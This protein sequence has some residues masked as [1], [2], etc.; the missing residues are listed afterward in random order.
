MP[1]LASIRVPNTST[2]F[3]QALVEQQNLA[4]I[5]PRRP[6]PDW[7]SL[8]PGPFF[9]KLRTLTPYKADLAFLGFPRKPSPTLAF[10]ND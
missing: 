3:F 6:I 8:T 2:T 9:R 5:R 7:R 4:D 10:S 1:A